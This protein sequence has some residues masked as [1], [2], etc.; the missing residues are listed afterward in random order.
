[1]TR[2]CHNDT[3]PTNP[4]HRGEETKT[5]TATCQLETIKVKQ[6]ALSSIVR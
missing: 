5:L 6:P 1:M 4:R 3:L 2:K